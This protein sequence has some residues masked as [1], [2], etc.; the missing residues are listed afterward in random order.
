HDRV[1]RRDQYGVYLSGYAPVPDP[2]GLTV[3]VLEVYANQDQVKRLEASMTRTVLLALVLGLVLTLPLSFLLRRVLAEPI[4]Q[5]TE[6][7]ARVG[8][9]DYATRVDLGGGAEFAGLGRAFNQ[10]VV[11][12]SERDFV[13][14]AFEKYVSKEVAEKVMAMPLGQAL[15]GERRRVTV[16]FT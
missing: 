11:G 2:D 3:G 8:K 5:L 4:R 7:P 6:A 15:S 10:M 9:G 16:V 1:Y 12:L 13:K 14:D